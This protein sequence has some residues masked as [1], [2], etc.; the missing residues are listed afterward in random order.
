VGTAAESGWLFLPILL[1]PMLLFMFAKGLCLRVARLCKQENTRSIADFLSARY[2]KRRGIASSVTLIVLLA[3]VPYIALQIKAITDSL[4]LISP[5]A[6]NL[7]DEVGFLIACAMIVFSLAFGVR[8]L[9]MAGYHGGLMSAIAFESVVKLI[10]IISAALFSLVFIFASPEHLDLAIEAKNTFFGPQLDYRFVLQTVISGLAIL[11]LP[12]MFHVVFVEQLSES[13]FRIGSKVFTTYLFIFILCIIVITIAGKVILQGQNVSGDSY[14]L[15]MPINEGQHWLTL[16]AFIGGFSASTAMTIVATVTLSYMLS[17]DVI[18]PMLLRRRKELSPSPDFSTALINARRATVLLV[19]GLAYLYQLAFAGHAALNDIGLTA[20]ALAVQLSPAMIFGIYSKQGNATGTYSALAVGCLLWFVT[21]FLPLMARSGAIS[22]GVLEYGIWGISWLRPEFLF[23]FEFSDAFSRGVTIS[24]CANAAAYWLASYL[25]KT[26][27]ADRIQAKAFFSLSRAK[28]ENKKTVY[29]ISDLYALLVKFLGESATQKLIYRHSQRGD[30]AASADLLDAVEHAL[31][32][33]VGV[34][35]AMA[36]IA[37]LEDEKKYL[38]V[39]DVVNIFEET[40]KAL[41]FNQDMIYAS[42]ENIS[43]GISV[44][45]EELAI[46]SWNRRYEQIFSYPEDK[47]RVGQPV[48]ELV[49]YNAQRGMLGPGSITELVSRRLAHLKS[50]KPYRVVRNHGE[51]V[52]EIKGSPLP[53]GGYVTTYTDISEFIDAQEKL[54]KTKLYLE[55]RVRQRTNELLKAEQEAVEANLIKSKFVA[56]ASHDILQP[57]N[58]ARL[59][60]SLLLEQAKKQGV[61]NVETIEYLNEAIESSESIIGTFLEISKLDTGAIKTSFSSV[62]VSAILDSLVNEFRVSLNQFLTLEYIPSSAVVY[63]D[64]RYLRRIVQNFLSNALKYTQKGRIALGCR[65]RKEYLEIFVYDRG[66]GIQESDQHKIFD[67]FYRVSAEH[68]IQGAG[69]GLAVV[70]RFSDLLEHP[71]HCHSEIGKGSSFSV[72]VPYGQP[73]Q[74]DN[75]SAGITVNMPE[76]SIIEGKTLLYVDDDEQNVRAMEALLTEWGANAIT[77][78]RAEDARM[79]VAD[80]NGIKPDMIIVDWDLNDNNDG[81]QLTSFLRESWGDVPACLVSA[82]PDSNLSALAASHKM[83]F[84][85]K[86]IKPGRLRAT[87]QQLLK[88][89]EIRNTR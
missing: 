89:E 66:L 15:F 26:I 63:T 79:F 43:S 35:S 5:R 30:T 51:C 68:D 16:L 85:R 45:N 40:T 62:P 64:P 33:I 19:V 27:L 73:L 81:I 78:T 18:L 13:H 54:E 84:L 60:S 88:R 87:L 58:A 46:V 39:E 25:G 48:E 53:N 7:G 67:D 12:R 31:S 34:P 4:M 70:K 1:G 59:Y 38:G 71:I 41:R 36:M 77:A 37:M 50:G 76:V 65:R 56:Q 23:G 11:C 22:E 28:S 14:V 72:C 82:A 74:S 10:A 20:F 52:I 32:G 47:L 24:L 49:R 75:R 2:G 9:E 80:S 86:P 42:F 55:E 8:R 6:Q 61:D 3:T 21:L 44:V 17:N 29:Q 83:E 69:L 57:L